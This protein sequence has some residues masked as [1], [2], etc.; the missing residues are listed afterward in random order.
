MGLIH[1]F[2]VGFKMHIPFFDTREIRGR[3]K[4][5]THI[6]RHITRVHS[7]R[8]YRHE[9]GEPT[10]TEHEPASLQPSNLGY[11]IFLSLASSKHF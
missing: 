8:M 2:L 11:H 7:A 4:T 3:W 1:L 5:M 9:L 6:S 10:R